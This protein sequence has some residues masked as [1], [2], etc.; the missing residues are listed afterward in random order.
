MMERSTL[1]ESI[2][3]R[4]RRME[5]EFGVYRRIVIAKATD[6]KILQVCQDGGVVTALLTYAFENG[7]IDG[8]AVSGVSPEKPLYSVPRLVTT[9]EELLE[10]A[11]TRYT[12]SPNLIAFQEG[13]K[14]DKKSL[15]F[16]GTPCQ[17]LAIRK[18]A[19][20]LANYPL[21]LV[22]GLL[23]TESFD[24]KGLMEGHIKEKLGINLSDIKKIN[25]KG[26]ILVTTKSGETT[27][28]PLKE[29]KQYMR[30][31]CSK[32]ID[33]SAEFA[34]ISVGGLGLNGWTFTILRTE[35]GEELFDSAVEQGY[36]KT[37]SIE[38]EQRAYDLLLKLSKIKRKRAAPRN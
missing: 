26:K 21:R 8:A 27:G 4:Q 13:L 16:V 12:Y 18:I 17:I 23:C 6:D 38:E 7:I 15:A 28:I 22:I 25:I 3:G 2:F 30:T 19:G 10:C 33:F 35:K 37:R 34:D 32:C 14:N 24:Y 9:P 5:E 1:E 31:A 29:A 20:R 11:G 36:L